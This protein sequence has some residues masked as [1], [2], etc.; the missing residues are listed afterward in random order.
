MLILWKKKDSISLPIFFFITQK[1]AS[2]YRIFNNG[3][4]FGREENMSIVFLVSETWILQTTYEIEVEGHE[5]VKL[6]RSV[7]E[8]RRIY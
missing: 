6:K 5:V 4:P 2:V 3:N 8:N 1:Q 7:S